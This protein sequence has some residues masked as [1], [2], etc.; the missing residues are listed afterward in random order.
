MVTFT[1]STAVG[2][3]I[4]VAGAGTVKKVFLE[5]GGKSALILLDDADFDSALLYGLGVCFHAGQGCAIPT[6]MLLPRSRYREAVDKLTPFF[7]GMTYG[8]PTDPQFI[9]GPVINRTQYDKILGLI[10]TGIEEGATLAAG[11]GAAKDMEKGFF[12]QPTLFT[13]VSNDMTIARQE[14]FGPVLVMI[15]FDDDDDAISIANDSDYGLSGAIFSADKS[16]ALAMARRIRTG[17]LSVNGGRF[18]SADAPFGG[19]KQSGV[20]REMGLEGLMEY[21]EIKTV[22]YPV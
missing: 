18:Y 14:I 12:I 15:P 13:D 8:D 20:G 16:R 21:M 9:M 4:M 6:R 7:Q 5:L 2:K 1:G 19:F 10:Q 17:T 11:G 22:A 3:R